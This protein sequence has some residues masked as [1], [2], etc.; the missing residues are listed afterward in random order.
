MAPEAD[1]SAIGHLKRQLSPRVSAFA[2]LQ[3]VTSGCD[4]RLDRVASRFKWPDAFTVDQ[5]IE[6][7]KVL[8]LDDGCFSRQLESR[9]HLR[10]HRV[11]GLGLLPLL[12]REAVKFACQCCDP[13]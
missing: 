6:R 4:W 3:G 13:A 5:D 7:A 9:R 11:M 10:P 2:H 8:Q 1:D 12:Q